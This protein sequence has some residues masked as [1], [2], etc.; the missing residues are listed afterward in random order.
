MGG[1]RAAGWPCSAGAA[2]PGLRRCPKRTPAFRS[3]GPPT[4]KAGHLHLQRPEDP[5]LYVGFEVDLAAALEKELGRHIEFVQYDF[6]SLI[7]GLQRGDFDFAMN[8]VEVTPDRGKAVRL[9]PAVLR[10]HA[11]TGRAEGRV[12]LQTRWSSAKSWAAWWA[13]W[14]T[15]PPNGCWTKMGI[16]KKV[17]GNQVEPYL[18]LELGRL[19]AVLLDLPIATYLRPA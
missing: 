3:A 7:S 8:G 14:R 4:P 6:K 16:T 2:N 5:N 18:D 12:A 1:R 19:D 15:P 13:R 17:Y 9:Q 10:L 11:A